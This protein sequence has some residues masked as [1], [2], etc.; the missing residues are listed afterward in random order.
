[1]TMKLA[2]VSINP[3]LHLYVEYVKLL[4]KISNYLF[5]KCLLIQWQCSLHLKSL[6][7]GL[8]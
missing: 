3:L 7:L 1:M 4:V 6:L 5:K 2:L 8:F